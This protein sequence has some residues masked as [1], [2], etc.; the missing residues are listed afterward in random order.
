M[1]TGSHSAKTL[2]AGAGGE[3]VELE[4][5]LALLA[6]L[7]LQVLLLLVEEL[8]VEGDGHVQRVLRGFRQPQGRG[9]LEAYGPERGFAL[10]ARGQLRQLGALA[11]P[12][13]FLGRRAL[14]G[15]LAEAVVHVYSGLA[16]PEIA[17]HRLLLG[18]CPPPPQETQYH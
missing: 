9:A 4:G 13:L 8:V 15:L 10:P 3:L 17:K 5:R 7:V 11:V 1:A 12:L 16:C 2:A 18:P 6:P 14:S